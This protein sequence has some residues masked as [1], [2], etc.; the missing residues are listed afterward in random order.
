MS[1]F[2]G[3]QIGFPKGGAS[4]YGL[5]LPQLAILAQTRGPRARSR[6]KDKTNSQVAGAEF[7]SRR[8]HSWL[9]TLAVRF[10]GLSVLLSTE[11]L[12]LVLFSSLNV[13]IR[14]KLSEVTNKS[15]LN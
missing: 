13:P 9:V 11:L 3:S 7:P 1:S 8:P 6:R 12:V 5:A 2:P 14:K 10:S 4:K 15:G